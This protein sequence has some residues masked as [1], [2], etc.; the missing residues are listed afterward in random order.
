MKFMKILLSLFLVLIVIAAGG[1]FYLYQG[2]KEGTLLEINE[3]DLLSLEYG[4]YP[5]KF[6]YERWSNE[7]KVTVND[8]K[9]TKI[10]I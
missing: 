6:N 1:I 4:V 8:H 9:I 7:L 10:D 5:G 3:V 2:L